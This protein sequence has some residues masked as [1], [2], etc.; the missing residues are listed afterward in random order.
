VGVLGRRAVRRLQRAQARLALELSRAQTTHDSTAVSHWRD[1][2]LLQRA[3][4]RALGHPEA[5]T[6][7]ERRGSMRRRM[8]ILTLTLLVLAAACVAVSL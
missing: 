2:V 1:E 7:D 6:L 8:L 4:L 5:V 3:R